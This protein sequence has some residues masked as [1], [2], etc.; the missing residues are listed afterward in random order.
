MVWKYSSMRPVQVQVVLGEVG[1]AGDVEHHAVDPV[2][3]HGVRGNLHGCGVEPAFAHERQQGVHVGGFGGGE[4]AGDGFPAGQD[5][6]G[7]DQPG[8]LSQRL[9]Q[10]IDEVGGG[11]LAVGARDAEQRRGRPPSGW[12][13]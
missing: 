12:L 7:P 10:G 4:Q 13:W 2:E 8:P 9:Q 11:G 5:L 1:E 3:G 6:D